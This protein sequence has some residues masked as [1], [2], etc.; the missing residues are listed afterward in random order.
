MTPLY[1]PLRTGSVLEADRISDVTST[2][3]RLLALLSLLQ[4][5]SIWVGS[6]LAERLGVTERTVRRDV[7][8]LRDLGYPVDSTGGA[9][10]GYRLGIGASLPPLMLQDD[11][12]VAIVVA[13]RLLAEGVVSGMEDAAVRSLATIDRLLPSALRHRV[14]ALHAATVETTRPGPR[15]DP[16]VLVV[17]AQAC[18]NSERVRVRYR[19]A[20]RTVDPYRLTF[21]DGRWYVLTRDARADQWRTLRVDAVADP[22]LTGHR[23]AGAPVPDQAEDDY[24]DPLAV[25]VRAAAT[26]S[27]AR[28][29]V[30]AATGTVE[31]ID[32]SM[33]LIRLAVDDLEWVE[34]FLFRLPFDV[35]VVEPPEL[36]ARFRARG[37][38]L[39]NTHRS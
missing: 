24:P 31:R 7:T 19:D 32:D 17:L 35:E 9:H 16:S 39:A 1:E 34:R 12:A 11:E 30:P 6:E 25:V 26:V 27:R 29:Y 14:E 8:R 23:F 38:R 33:C 10:G 5:R 22:H 36:R 4:S 2:S 13:L 3:G 18:R 20:E 15:V 37:E 21:Q 28:A